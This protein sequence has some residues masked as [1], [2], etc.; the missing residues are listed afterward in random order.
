MNESNPKKKKVSSSAY[1]KYTGMA[2][3]MLAYILVGYFIGSFLD[4]KVGTDKPYF[5]AGGTLLLLILY[6][7]KV[8]RD[9]SSNKE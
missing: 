2:F 5:T 9:L 3:E 8:V 6:L 7:V 1:L 4:K